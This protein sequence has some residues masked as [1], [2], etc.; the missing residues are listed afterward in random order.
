M[1]AAPAVI[2]AALD[3]AQIVGRRDPGPRPRAHHRR[4]RAA[5]HPHHRAGHRRAGLGV[6]PDLR[7]DRDLAAGH[8]EPHPAPSGTTCGTHERATQAR[9]APALR[10][11]ACESSIDADGE[12]LTQSNHNLEGYWE[13]PDETAA[14]QQGNWFH[15]GDGGV[16]RRRR[17][18]RHLRPE[19]GRDHL[20]RRE[21]LL[22]RGRGRTDVTRR[23]CKRGRGHRHPGREVGRAGHRRWSSP[24]A[25][26]VTAE[27]LIA[28]C[29]DQ[30][31]RLQVP[32][33]RSS[34]STRCRA[35]PRA[36]CR[37]SS[38]ASRSGPARTVRSTERRA[39]V[40]APRAAARPAAQPVR[41]P[42]VEQQR[43]AQH[44]RGREP[45]RADR[46]RRVVEA[47]RGSARSTPA[48]TQTSRTSA[49]PVLRA[50]RRSGSWHDDE[51]QHQRG[52]R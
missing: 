31:G 21:R 16:H 23:R 25:R 42:A 30:P 29:R 48:A 14:A 50:P 33:A 8:R 5:A 41:Q 19:E 22:D 18:P 27:D 6:H 36:S 34:S 15:T 40:P 11:W 1:C 17:L 47:P 4:R 44:D 2:S 26:E 35:P 45:D 7:P 24:T 28:H 52:A 46:V 32:E 12:V 9:R 13:Q 20:R 10:P 43:G 39:A 49:T 37:S 51:E 38:C 3:G